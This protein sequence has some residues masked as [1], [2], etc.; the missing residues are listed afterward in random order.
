VEEA[1]VVVMIAAAADA[2]PFEETSCNTTIVWQVNADYFTLYPQNPHC[3]DTAIQ[4]L[5]GGYTLLIGL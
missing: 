4:I 2:P 5:G 3:S 1:V